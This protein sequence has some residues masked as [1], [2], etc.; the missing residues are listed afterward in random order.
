MQK[1]F[2]ENVS[3]FGADVDGIFWLIFYITTVWFFITEG[4]IVYFIFRYRRRPGRKA[5]YAAGDTWSQLAWVLAPLALVIVLDLIIDL[6]G[7]DVWAKVKLQRPPTDFVVHA[8]GKQ[9]NWEF[10]YPG[11]DGKFG[12]DDD[13]IT[14][15]E[16]H[17]P[18]GK[19]IHVVL[20]SK[21]VIHSF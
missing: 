5:V 1:W 2:P 4:L 17:I 20:K 9:F 8:V 18:V 19:P 3:T 13:L 6:R 14:D 12:S 7:A 11:A 10:I 15:N 21:D 16:L